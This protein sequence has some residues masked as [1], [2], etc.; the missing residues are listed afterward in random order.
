MGTQEGG[1]DRWLP[2]EERQEMRNSIAEY[3]KGIT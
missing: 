1:Q 3:S 2:K